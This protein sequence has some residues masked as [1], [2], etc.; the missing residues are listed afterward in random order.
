MLNA[1]RASKYLHCIFLDR[2]MAGE[3]RQLQ[4]ASQFY[5]NAAPPGGGA[6]AKV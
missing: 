6:P 4:S 1:N 3:Y 5:Q 2:F